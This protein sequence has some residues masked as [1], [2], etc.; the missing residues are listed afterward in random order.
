V[1]LQQAATETVT[2]TG[3]DNGNGNGKRNPKGNG[4]TGCHIEQVLLL[5]GTASGACTL[6]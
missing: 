6:I 4:I 3:N 5:R 2:E 1:S